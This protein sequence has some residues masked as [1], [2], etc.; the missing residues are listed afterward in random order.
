[1]SEEFGRSI[2][3]GDFNNDGFDDMAVGIP[4]KDISGIADAGA[5]SVIYGSASKLSAS[6]SQIWS[7]DT[8][9]ITGIAKTGIGMSEEFGDS[10][11]N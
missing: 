6:N 4:G 9:G 11:N 5:V 8:S 7:L 3:V 1:M 2:S 10:L